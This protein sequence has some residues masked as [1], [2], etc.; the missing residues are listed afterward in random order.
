MCQGPFLSSDKPSSH[1]GNWKRCRPCKGPAYRDGLPSP[2][3]ARDLNGNTLNLDYLWKVKVATCC[4][5]CFLWIIHVKWR[6]RDAVYT[7]NLFIIDYHINMQFSQALPLKWWNIG[8]GEKK[9]IK[10]LHFFPFTFNIWPEELYRNVKPNLLDTARCTNVLIDIYLVMSFTWAILLGWAQQYRA[11][12]KYF[13][14]LVLNLSCWYGGWADCITHCALVR[15]IGKI[16]LW[17]KLLLQ[18][19]YSYLSSEQYTP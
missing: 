13:W 9:K 17:N 8:F 16:P 6:A 11:F 18:W 4:P 5:S 12:T 19:N 3:F 14:K 15:L 7:A 10:H 2:A 1:T